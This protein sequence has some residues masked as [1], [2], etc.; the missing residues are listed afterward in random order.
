V[1]FGKSCGPLTVDGG[2][3]TAPDQTASVKRVQL[4]ASISRLERSASHSLTSA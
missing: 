3:V 4:H 2:F 1:G